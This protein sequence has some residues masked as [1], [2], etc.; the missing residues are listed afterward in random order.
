ML[1]KESLKDAQPGE[2]YRWNDTVWKM[3]RIYD[4]SEE[5]AKKYDLYYRRRYHTHV[6]EA[7]E[8]YQGVREIDAAYTY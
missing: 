5:Y 8:G 4:I 2:L 3:D 1:I 7:P 6:V